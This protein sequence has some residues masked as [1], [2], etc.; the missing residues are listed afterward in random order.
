LL[1]TRRA[2]AFA[3]ISTIPHW[4]Y[5]SALRTDQG[6][7]YRVVVWTS[8][9]A[10]LLALL[11][12][13]LA[14]TQFRRTKPL[15]LARRSRT[16][17]G[18]RWHYITGAVFGIFTLTFAFSGLLSMEPFAWTNAEGLYVSR[19]RVSPEAR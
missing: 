16:P 2:R 5:F 15:R 13:A 17:A 7:W 14:V 9:L 6:V 8:E 3:W 1:T 4:L 10:C 19:R 11:G 18:M 12:L